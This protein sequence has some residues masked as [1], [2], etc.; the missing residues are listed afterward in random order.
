[1]RCYFMRD[2]RIQAVE[3]IENVKDDAAAIQRAKELLAERLINK[4]V[5]QPDGFEL[6]DRARFI[7]RY[8]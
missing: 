4:G 1:M 3:V 8:P 5:L 6:W 7:Q 2:G